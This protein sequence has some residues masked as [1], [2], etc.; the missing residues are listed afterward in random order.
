MNIHP[1]QR[2]GDGVLSM[3]LKIDEAQVQRDYPSSSKLLESVHD[4]RHAHCYSRGAKAAKYFG[5]YP[6]GFTV[7]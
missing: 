4:E 6:F 3:L 5:E 1:Q 2:L 7:E